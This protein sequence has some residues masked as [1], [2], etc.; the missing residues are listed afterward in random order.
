MKQRLMEDLVN[1]FED[2]REIKNLMGKYAASL[3]IRRDAYMFDDFWSKEASDVSLGFNNGFYIGAESIRAYYASVQNKYKVSSRILQEL[4]PEQLGNLSEEEIYGVGSLEMKP[5]Q[6]AYIQV[7]GD[8]RTA[9]GLWAANGNSAEITT[10]GPT[11]RWTWGFFAVDFIYEKCEWRIW[12]L[13]YLED[14]NVQAGHDWS[15]ASDDWAE[16]PEFAALS[17]CA[18]PEPDL[19]KALRV[20][21][22]PG[23]PFTKTPLI[24][25]PYETFS[26]TFSYGPYS[27]QAGTCCM[28]PGSY[29]DSLSFSENSDDEM[30]LAKVLAR[31]AAVDAMNLRVYLQ[32]NNLRK[33]ELDELW[34]REEENRKTASFGK[35]WG[36]Y[37]GMESIEKYYVDH[38]NDL[39]QEYLDNYCAAHPGF[40]N[41]PANTGAGYSAIF[42]VSAPSVQVAADCKTLKALFYSVGYQNIPQSDGT[43]QARWIAQKVAADFILEKDGWKIWHLLEISDSEWKP[44]INYHD[45]MPVYEQDDDILKIEFGTPDI[46]VQTHDRQFCWADNYP[47]MPV[48]YE[49]FTDD[50]SWGPEGFKPFMPSIRAK[51]VILAPPTQPTGLS[52]AGARKD[53]GSE[54]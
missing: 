40:E 38:H 34:V 50:I 23:R 1:R 46:T 48:P 27:N 29:S 18:P 9:K 11:T 41:T 44:G 49:I 42:P 6:S 32:A 36:Y 51:D 21:Y 19:K 15:E 37:T 24:P 28:N 17:E 26:E 43:V 39:M 20:P 31:D 35:N 30:L 13:R 5:L 22:T 14:I 12:H 47:A 52:T 54:E 4:F 16:R 8:R 33:K 10:A 7:A 45:E 25:E 2:K 53:E 3:I